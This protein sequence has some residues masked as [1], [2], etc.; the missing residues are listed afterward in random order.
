VVGLFFWRGFVSF[1]LFGAR[2]TKLV[3]GA[4]AEPENSV[5]LGAFRLAC[6]LLIDSQTHSTGENDEHKLL[7]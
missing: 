3:H 1:A 5:L 7:Q 2:L 6:F 4:S